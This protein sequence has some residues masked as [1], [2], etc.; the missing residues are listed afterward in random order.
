MPWE[1][2]AFGVLVEN[3]LRVVTHD[4]QSLLFGAWPRSE[5]KVDLGGTAGEGRMCMSHNKN[6]VPMSGT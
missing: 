2:S 4:Q 3:R 5:A 1:T 6:L